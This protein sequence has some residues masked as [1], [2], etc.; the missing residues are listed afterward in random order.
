M[1][2]NRILCHLFATFYI[3]CRSYGYSRFRLPET[4]LG[5][6]LTILFDTVCLSVENE[7]SCV[8]EAIASVQFG[9]YLFRSF[10]IDIAMNKR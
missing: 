2:F 1:P 7:L 6:L 9:S 4:I 5:G 8:Y 3:A 10:F